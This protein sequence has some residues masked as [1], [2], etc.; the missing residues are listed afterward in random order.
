VTTGK[1]ADLG[2]TTAKLA[3]AAVTETQLAASVAGNGLTGGAGTALAVNNDGTTIDIAADTVKVKD[4]G[5][6]STQLAAGIGRGVLANGYAQ[7]TSS[8]SSLEGGVDLTSLTVTVTV[9][10]SSRIRI[11][12]SCNLAGS[13]AGA[14]I[15]LNVQEGATV[16]NS[17]KGHV[18]TANEGDRYRAEVILT[19]S[20]G[21]HTYKL[22]AVRASGSGTVTMNASATEPAFIL[23]EDLGA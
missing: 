4:A 9:R 10:A 23:V 3:N 22:N 5:I 20:T 12:G 8:Q 7:V 17:G 18:V 21:S 1:L 16:L 2:V 13:V 11:T 14:A 15:T 19:P 6:G